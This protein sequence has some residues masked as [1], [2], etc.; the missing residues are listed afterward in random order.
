MVQL[1]GVD[2]FRHVSVRQANG[3]ERINLHP[4]TCTLD[5]YH[6]ANAINH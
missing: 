6:K 4:L 5:E 1:L 3:A 2:T